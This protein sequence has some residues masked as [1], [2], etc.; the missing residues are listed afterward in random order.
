MFEFERVKFKDILDI[1][2][3]LI[4]KNKITSIVGQSGSGKSTLLKLFNKMLSPASGR[5][6]FNGVDLKSINSI[7]LRRRVVMLSQNPGIFRGSIRDN[8]LI[9]LKYS[10]KKLASE[11]DMLKVLKKVILKK[12]LDED[13]KNL[14][15][16]E[17]QRLALARM[18][19]MDPD[20]LLLDEPSSAL[21]EKT[22]SLII[23]RLVD[24]SRENNKALIMVTHSKKVAYTFSDTVIELE[25]GK[26]IKREDL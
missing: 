2:S 8:L 17:K 15:G 22:E 18:L 25:G 1:S 10:E 24:H 5:I 11:E 9:G 20:I 7:D 4:E 16:G 21:D 3:L 13:S 14:S 26:I 19:L 6:L 12:S 23:D